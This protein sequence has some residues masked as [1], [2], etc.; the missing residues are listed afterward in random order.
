[1]LD[2]ILDHRNVFSENF[3]IQTNRLSRII[4]SENE[5]TRDMLKVFASGRSS[6]PTFDSERP[7]T[8]DDS[9]VAVSREASPSGRPLHEAVKAGN[10]QRI[11]GLLRDP[12]LNI[13][14]LDEN[15]RSALH[16]ACM[17]GRLDIAKYLRW[18]GA[19]ISIDDDTGQ[20]PLHYAVKGGYETLA[21][22][23]LAGGANQ[24]MEDDESHAPSY[25]AKG[26]FTMSW[27]FKFGH[28]IESV[29]PETRNTVLIAAAILGDHNSIQSI[30]DQGADMEAQDKEGRTALHQAC[31]L[32][33][34]SCIELL[35]S[36]GANIEHKDNDDCTPI[37]IGIR[38]K[39]LEVVKLVIEKGANLEARS[40][41]SKLTCL[42]E[43]M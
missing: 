18:K 14:I 20:T 1:M 27:M 29:D 13:N 26:S 40:K 17:D 33:H 16:L 37:L 12:K 24:D 2:A 11:R 5:K 15:G 19:E 38:A 34:L 23:L 32:G 9:W 8:I 30:L 4:I 7:S 10:M 41:Q 39:Q 43:G 22:F 42:G 35:I 31:G 21:R 36:R 3:E 25:Y 28:S 6:A